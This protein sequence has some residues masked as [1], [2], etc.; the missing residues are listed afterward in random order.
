MKY[1]TEIISKW[2]T[3]PDGTAAP[4]FDRLFAHDEW[5]DVTVQESADA[6]R[7]EIVVIRAVLSNTELDK[8]KSHPQHYCL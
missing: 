1:Q 3:L 4:L 6:Q 7:G 5:E 8:V 2:E